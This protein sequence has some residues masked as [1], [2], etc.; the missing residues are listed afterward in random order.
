MAHRSATVV[1]PTFRRLEGLDRLLA[2]LTTLDD[3]GVGWDVV[4]VDNDD[5]PGA[6]AVVERW[7]A[8]LPV[9]HVREPARGSAHARNRGSAE[10]QADLIVFLDDDVTPAP[11]WLRELLAP[12]LAGRCDAADGT[13]IL[14]PAVSRPRWFD[15]QGI[16]GYLAAHAPAAGEGKVGKDDF[17]ITATLAVDRALMQ[18]SGG[19]DPQL[20][21][22]D[23][24]QLVNDDVL[25]TD[26]LAAAGGRL[27]HAPAA[28]VVHELPASRLTPRY[29]LR[30]SYTQGRSDWVY[31]AMSIGR[32]GAYEQ[33]RNWIF[34]ELRRRFKEGITQPQV[35]FH[36]ACDLT[37]VAGAVTEALRRGLKRPTPTP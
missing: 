13:V 2:A 35:A 5:P 25:L 26:R 18:R 22:R 29:L 27:R 32:R 7:A 21:P 17:L 16:G 30:R 10:V 11:S 3:P 9:R 33:Q 14:D 6:E 31:L 37:R 12:I 36:T 24:V 20:G 28:V 23:G 8:R 1:I 15:E 19:F 4:V 34:K